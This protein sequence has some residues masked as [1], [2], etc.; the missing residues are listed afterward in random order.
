MS[1]DRALRLLRDA[2]KEE[3]L[4]KYQV[5]DIDWETGV[6]SDGDPATFVQ[7]SVLPRRGRTVLTESEVGVIAD[8]DQQDRTTRQENTAL[9]LH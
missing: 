9:H 1:P 2:I 7:I 4:F 8:E 5:Q 3:G 6:D